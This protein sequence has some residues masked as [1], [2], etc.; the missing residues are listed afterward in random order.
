MSFYPSTYY[1][2]VTPA[3]AR[4]A[5]CGK[6]VNQSKLVYGQKDPFEPYE[7]YCRRCATLLRI[8]DHE[9]N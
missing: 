9:R 6:W 8:H 4:C 5:E 1:I 3:G 2:S 7:H